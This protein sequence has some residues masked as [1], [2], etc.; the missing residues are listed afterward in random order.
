M[1][2]P[3]LIN[4]LFT[5]NVDDKHSTPTNPTNEA[6]LIAQLSD[7]RDQALLALENEK[8]ISAEL[9]YQKFALD[10]HAVVTITDS[11]GRIK[12]ANDKFCQLSGYTREELLGQT[13]CI[14]KSGEHSKAFY[15]GLWKTISS[16]T[17][18]SGEV[19]NKAKDGHYYWVKA[20][21]VPFKDTNGKIT[22]YVAIRADITKRKEHEQQLLKT[23]DALAI[24]LDGEKKSLAKLEVAMT[25]LEIL[26]TT[27]KLTGLPNRTVFADRL[28]Q[29]IKYANRNNTKFAVL[30]FDY[31]RFKLVNDC[32]GHDVG[33]LLLQSIAEIFKANLRDT[34]TAA[35]FGGDEFLVL[36]ENLSSWEDAEAKAETLRLAFSMPHHIGKHTVI[37]TSSIGLITN[38]HNN[39][40]ANEILR[41]ADAA[42]YY[43]KDHGGNRVMVF[44]QRMH[45]KAIDRLTLEEDLQSA[46]QQDQFHLLFQPILNLSNGELKGFEALLRWEHPT[47]GLVPP[48]QFIP[49]A[50]ESEIINDIGNWVLN[51]TAKQISEWNQKFGD[52]IKLSINANVSKRQ[53]LHPDFLQNLLACRQEFAIHAAQLPIEIT[54]TVIVDAK[55]DVIPL[56]H[57]IRANGFPIVMDDFGTGVS[58]LSTLHAYPIDV[59]KIDQS[60]IHVL[61]GDRPLLAVVAAITT[62]AENLGIHT[63][64]EGIET[65]EIVGALQSIGCQLGQGY[66]FAKPLSVSQAESFIQ[67]H[68]QS[69]TLAA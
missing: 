5:P 51:N 69:N 6:E 8:K 54:E 37:S 1:K 60:F 29:A 48:A 63:V 40:S 36:L 45:D 43:A 13:H 65:K 42:M 26:A 9:E 61:N 39:K 55:S 52:Q 67:S 24:A 23:N 38:Q 27:D 46:V 44:D 47:R 49:I 62:L 64:A 17:P 7:S 35:R 28:A 32:L 3:R 20:T 56:L 57:E 16:G 41:D 19:K 12:Y 66:F 50:E 59:L 4:K 18:W 31:D 14:L 58:S 2:P 53:L 15:K 68:L 11:R 25:E 34:D 22:K 21:I 33:D 30:F 10:Q